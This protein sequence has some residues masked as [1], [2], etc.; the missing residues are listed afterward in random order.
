MHLCVRARAKMLKKQKHAYFVGTSARVIV[1][2]RAFNPVEIG[3]VLTKPGH[4]C[5][6]AS[7]LRCPVSIPGLQGK[8]NQNQSW[9]TSILSRKTYP[10]LVKILLALAVDTYIQVY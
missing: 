8:N 4:Y 1:H 3:T 6:K 9:G 2:G 5:S 10:G 7:L